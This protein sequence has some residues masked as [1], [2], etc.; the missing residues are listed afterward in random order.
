M[1]ARDRKLAELALAHTCT[2]RYL[3]GIHF[4]GFPILVIDDRDGSSVDR[5][6]YI[7]IESRWELYSP[8][9]SELPATQNELP[10]YTVEQLAQ[11]SASLRKHPIIAAEIAP[12]A[13]HLLLR[14]SDGRT[15]F[16]HGYDWEYECWELSAGNT[17][18]V[19]GAEGTLAVWLSD[20]LKSA[21]Q[22][23]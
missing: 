5:E 17:L 18:V 12:D 9:P 23:A 1:N 10:E 14:F 4:Y 22:H 8:R 13:P 6:A 7:R 2:G 15:L 19:A 20:E 16:V 11:A 3:C 21:S